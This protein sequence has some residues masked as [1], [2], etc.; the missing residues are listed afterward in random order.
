MLAQPARAGGTAREGKSASGAARRVHVRRDVSFPA[1]NRTPQ[2][3][4][5]CQRDTAHQRLEKEA[6]RN[7]PTV[8]INDLPGPLRE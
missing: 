1:E 7:R 8:Y 6:K 3:I 4:L 2:T 5:H